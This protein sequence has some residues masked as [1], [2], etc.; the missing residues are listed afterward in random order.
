MVAKTF[1][2]STSFLITRLALTPSFSES[3]LTVMP[4]E[5]VISRSIGGGAAA[6]ERRRAAFAEI[7]FFDVLTAFNGPATGLAWARRVSVGGGTAGSDAKRAGRMHRP[8]A[9]PP[10]GLAPGKPGPPGPR[11]CGD[12][13]EG[14]RRGNWGDRAWRDDQA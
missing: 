12:L 14:G 1:F 13:G 6:I 8:R 10:I 3:S 4:S 9:G 11:I 7:S 5:T 2:V